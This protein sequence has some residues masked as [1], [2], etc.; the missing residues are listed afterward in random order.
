A[1][2]SHAGPARRLADQRF[3]PAAPGP[4]QP[5]RPQGLALVERTRPPG[6]RPGPGALHPS[7]LQCRPEPDLATVNTAFLRTGPIRLPGSPC[8]PGAQVFLFSDRK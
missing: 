4:V 6:R 2:P 8:P 5:D 1:G 7:R 3:G